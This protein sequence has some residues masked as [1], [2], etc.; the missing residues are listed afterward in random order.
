[1][2]TTIAD[3]NLPDA[4]QMQIMSRNEVMYLSFIHVT[5]Q[6]AMN[7]HEAVRSDQ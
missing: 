3:E 4:T 5:Q 1:M 6:I 7:N 2:I